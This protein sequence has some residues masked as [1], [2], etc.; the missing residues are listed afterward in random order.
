[1][2]DNLVKLCE[3][4]FIAVYAFWTLLRMSLLK[5]RLKQSEQCSRIQVTGFTFGT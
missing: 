3:F 2:F 1:M 4:I 5:E